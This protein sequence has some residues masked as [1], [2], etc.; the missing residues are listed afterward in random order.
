M[1]KKIVVHYK[2][3]DYECE[4]YS[5]EDVPQL[6]DIFYFWKTSALLADKLSLQNPQMPSTFSERFCCLV[7]GTVYKPGRG[8][9]AFRLNASNRVVSTIEIKA[10]TTPGGFTD[11]KRTPLPDEVMWLSLADY[12]RLAFEIFTIPRSL[13]KPYIRKSKTKRERVTLSLTDI[14]TAHKLTPTWW[15]HVTVAINAEKDGRTP[16]KP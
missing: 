16:I 14:V 12:D 4:R 9:D 10:T 1:P 8:I 7:S 2:G 6:L 13:L 11:I 5:E 15:G 3:R